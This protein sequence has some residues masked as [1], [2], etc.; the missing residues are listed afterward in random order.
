MIGLTYL[1][2]WPGDIPS[3]CVVDVPTANGIEE[4][5]IVADSH[6]RGRNLLVWEVGSDGHRVLVELPRE[7]LSGAWRLWV[8][9]DMLDPIPPGV[10]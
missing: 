8:T 6:V 10:D 5:V 4:Q 1:R 3:E 7:A 9:R 2:R